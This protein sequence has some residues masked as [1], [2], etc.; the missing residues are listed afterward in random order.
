MKQSVILTGATG[1]VGSQVLNHL[2][3]SEQVEKIISFGRRKTGIAASNLVEVIHED[4]L[5][6]S[7]LGEAAPQVDLCIYCLGTYQAQVSPETYERITCDFLAAFVQALAAHHPGITFV[8]FSAQGA[9]PSGKSRMTF[10]K[11]KGRAENIV[12][13][14]TFPKTYIF[15]PGYIHAT[16]DRVPPGWMYKVLAPLGRTLLSLFPHL[17]ST[18]AELAC[19]M[20][21]VGLGAA[22]PSHVFESR[23]IRK[24]IENKQNK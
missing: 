5:D 20:V 24:W 16:G 7:N 8:L 19:A 4:F 21:Q 14:A 3:Q 15:R 17:G 18:D 10:S 23:D 22:E 6:F 13:A 9:D 2:L 1:M 11:V 12:L